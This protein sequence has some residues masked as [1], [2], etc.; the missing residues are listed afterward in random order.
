MIYSPESKAA[1]PRSEDYETGLRVMAALWGP[2]P[3]TPPLFAEFNDNF[4]IEHLYG[5]V[6]SRPQLPLNL[7]SIITVTALTTLGR[8]DELRLHILAARRQG[9]SREQ[10]CE[11]MTHLAHY[12]GWPAAIAGLRVVDAVFSDA[13]H[14]TAG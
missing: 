4:V 3:I 1:M 7:R 8:T 11:T 13:E 6:W 10:L 12:C 9:F 14:G 2:V 5:R